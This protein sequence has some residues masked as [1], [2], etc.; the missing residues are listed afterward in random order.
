MSTE[1]A[2]VAIINTQTNAIGR[3]FLARGIASKYIR[4]VEITVVQ[5]YT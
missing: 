5:E 3:T 2:Y 1:T 4:M